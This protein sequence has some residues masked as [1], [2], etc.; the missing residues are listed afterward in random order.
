MHHLQ[1]VT[2]QIIQGDSAIDTHLGWVL[3]GQVSHSTE[4]NSSYLSH[5]MLIH[6]GDSPYLDNLLKKFWDLESLDVSSDESSVHD[7]YE[8]SVQFQDNRYA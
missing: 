4:L 3:S 2:G 1:I 6:S 8:N 5:S 7:S